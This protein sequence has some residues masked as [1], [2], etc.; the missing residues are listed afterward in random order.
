MKQ[1]L[2]LRLLSQ[3]PYSSAVRN[4]LATGTENA[5]K[6]EEPPAGLWRAI[7]AWVS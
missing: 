2:S 4:F 5:R 3:K 6:E 7:K 1:L